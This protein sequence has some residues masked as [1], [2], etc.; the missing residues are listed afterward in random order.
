LSCARVRGHSIGGRARSST[1][2]RSSSAASSTTRAPAALFASGC[3][4]LAE[5]DHHSD[6]KHQNQRRHDDE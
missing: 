4:S 3:R 6:G 1:G 5:R 2:A